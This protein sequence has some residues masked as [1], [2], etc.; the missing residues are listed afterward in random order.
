MNFE[1]LRLFVRVAATLNI[2]AAGKEMGLSP[3]AASAKLNKLEEVLGARLIHRTTRQISLTEDGKLFLPH[4]EDLLFGAEAAKAAVGS[5]NVNPQGKLRVTAPASFG[6]MHLIPALPDFLK[7]YPNLNV[8]LRLSDGIEDVIEG[9]FDI[10]IRDAALD[11]SSLVARKLAR[12]TRIAVVSPQYIEQHG[13]PTHPD[14]LAEHAC[15]SL[16]GVES[17]SFDC[18]DDIYRVKVPNRLVVDN[19]EAVRDACIGGIGI[20]ITSTWCSYQALQRGDLV[21]VL[22]DFPLKS[23]SAIWAVYPSSR[24]LAP[25]TRAFIDFFSAYYGDTPYWESGND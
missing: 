24:L 20:T 12:D 21:Q 10:A 14:Q 9:G 11:D 7:A 13:V 18:G 8:D 25:K 6:R 19:G 22:E 2:S 3:A 1:H 15:I 5:G 23:A 16:A 17:W 4:A